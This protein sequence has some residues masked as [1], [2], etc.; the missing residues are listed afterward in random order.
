MSQADEKNREHDPDLQGN[1][2]LVVSSDGSVLDV[3]EAPVLACGEPAP[4]SQLTSLRSIWPREI[5]HRLQ[6]HVGRV[7]RS[8]ACHRDEIDLGQDHGSLEVIFIAQGRDRALVIVRDLSAQS[9]KLSSIRELAYS[10]KVTGLPNREFLLGELQKIAQTQQL[11]E[12]RAAMICLNVDQFDDHGYVLSPLQQDEIMRELAQRMTRQLRGTNELDGEGDLERLS[13]VA[14]TDFRQ[15]GVVLPSIADGEDAEAVIER[16]LAALTH[17]VPVGARSI[18][19]TAHGGVALFPQDGTDAETLFDN[20]AAALEDAR[21]SQSI[22]YKLHS[23]TVRLRTLQRQDLEVELRSALDNEDY[24]LSFL[25]IVAAGDYRPVTIEA[26][27]RWPETILGSHSTRKV[28]Q[29]AER[30]GLILPIGEWVLTHAARQLLRWRE[31]GHTELRLAINLSAQEFSRTDLAARVDRLLAGLSLNPADVDFEIHEHML[32]RDAIAGF[33][34]CRALKNLGAR[35]VIDDYGTGA[36]SLAHLSQ[37]PVDA[38]KID[39]T[40]VSNMEHSDRDQA[41]CETAIAVAG[42][43]GFE[44]VA[45]GVENSAQAGMLRDYGCSYL[46]GFLFCEPLADDDVLAYLNE[47][48]RS[49]GAVEGTS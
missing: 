9:L 45:E 43:L 20:A 2:V 38:I 42:K 37:S 1:M 27:L 31:A 48:M 22:P 17:P 26:L 46:Q 35:I 21:N 41:A 10:D 6:Q 16:L 40:F 3:L 24:T 19:A 32:F 15:F 7:V 39:R 11:R 8:R 23:G 44:V 13:I 33:A 47:T 5:A 25:P 4:K 29:I 34:A 49:D 36:C 12:G 18:N 14:R 30:T 28:V